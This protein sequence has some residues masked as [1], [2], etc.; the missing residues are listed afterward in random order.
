M[1]WDA[2]KVAACFMFYSF[3]PSLL[4]FFPPSAADVRVCVCERERETE[5]DSHASCVVPAFR[6]L[7]LPRISAQLKVEH[8]EE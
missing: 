1:P 8:D 2:S 7:K 5:K 6:L 4:T 3:D